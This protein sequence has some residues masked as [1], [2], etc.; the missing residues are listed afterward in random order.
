MNDKVASNS[1]LIT[2]IRLNLFLIDTLFKIM[3]KVPSFTLPDSTSK[4]VYSNHAL[5][6]GI[7]KHTFGGISIT[8]DPKS[9][10]INSCFLY[11]LA[12]CNS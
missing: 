4:I 12:L 8:Q 5:Q 9:T 11:N 3:S 10:M 7:S 1:V 2:N 6:Q